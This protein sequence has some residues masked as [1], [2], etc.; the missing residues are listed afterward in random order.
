LAAFSLGEWRLSRFFGTS[1]EFWLSLQNQYDAD[2]ARLAL[3]KELESIEPY[4]ATA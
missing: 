3:G 4:A 1:A 2:T